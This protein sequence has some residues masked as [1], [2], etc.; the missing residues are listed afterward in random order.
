[1]LNRRP[2]L[3][4]FSP[5]FYQQWNARKEELPRLEVKMQATALRKPKMHD[6]VKYGDR[7]CRI[8]YIHNDREVNLRAWSGVGFIADI[9]P[10]TD[11]I[12]ANEDGTFPIADKAPTLDDLQTAG[13][14]HLGLPD[15]SPAPIESPSETEAETPL[16]IH[17]GRGLTAKTRDLLP[18]PRNL[19]I[20]GDE[21]VSGLESDI[22]KSGWIK[23]VVVNP[24]TNRI[25]SG[26]RRWLAAR[27]LG[28]AE[29]PVEYRVF[30]NEL[31]ELEALLLENA[32]R[33]KTP[34]QKVREGEVWAEIEGPLARER[35]TAN[36]RQGDEKPVSPNL[37]QRGT[38]KVAEKVAEKVDMKRSTYEKAKKVV[39]AA[40]SFK[41]IGETSKATDLLNTL[42]KKSVDAAYKTL[43]ATAKQAE[44]QMKV[45]AAQQAAVAPQELSTYSVLYIDPPWEFEVYSKA[46]GSGR[47]A[48]SHY[49]TMSL[50]DMKALPIQKLMNEDCAVFL[51][52]TW[53]TLAEALELACAWGLTY[54]TCAF[55]WVKMNKN[56]TEKP[57]TG[58]GY[59]TR[60]NSEPCLLFTRGNPSRQAK[61]VAQAFMDWADETVATPIGP[62]SEKPAAI[63]ERIEA[64]LDGPYCEVFARE[65]R[66]GW[67]S[68]GNEIDGRDIR[69]VLA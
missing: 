60:A 19:E 52:T 65:C 26:H 69:E 57:F 34:E 28:L 39:E 40:D 18:H 61:D 20:Y 6:K 48:E 14:I 46:T 36:L 25:V 2:K 67:A 31:D 11:L 35:Q 50:E 17:I 42:N 56:Q 12:F 38:G 22:I 21:D 59:W 43:V 62:H 44:H 7:V 55:N 9:I 10:V 66:D 5:E 13:A 53:P 23:A 33:E 37:T 29:V 54:K 64:L 63:Y 3:P 24:A 58:M 15:E 47:S 1:M 30:S 32:S 41:A 49:S 4:I 45:E 68:I 16:P 51:W 27:N 8:T